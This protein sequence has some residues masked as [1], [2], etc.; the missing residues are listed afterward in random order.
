MQTSLD[1]AGRILDITRPSVMGVLNVTPDSFSDGGRYTTLNKALEHAREMISQGAGIIDVGGESTRPNAQ[2]V[3]E[4]EEI[5]RVVP[6]IEALSVE[7]DVIVSIDTS[8]A[9]VMKAA[10]QA[11]AGIINDVRALSRPGALEAAVECG[12]PV[13]LMHSLVEQPVQGFVPEYNDVME[14]VV[15]YL[16]ERV[17]VC[18]LA[19]IAKE[20]II[21]DPGFGGGMF[22][23]TPAYDLALVKRFAELH[24]LGMPVLAGVSRKSFIG[25]VLGNGADERLA[26]SLAVALMLAQAGAQI[27]RVH[28]VKETVDMLAMLEAV[29][30]A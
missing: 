17:K 4:N 19:G 18:E 3:S 20:K 30:A 16:V 24:S 10:V 6:V 23:K 12:V 13:V 15:E 26:G 5:D 14:S 8:S 29:A 7:S 28:D 21:L 25:S 11:G 27:V 9:R 2:L 1:C 22:G